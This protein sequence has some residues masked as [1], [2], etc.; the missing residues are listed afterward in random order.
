MFDCRGEIRKKESWTLRVKSVSTRAHATNERTNEQTNSRTNEQKG[1]KRALSVAPSRVTAGVCPRQGT[2]GL[3]T[4]LLHADE[5]RVPL[6]SLLRTFISL[7]Q[8]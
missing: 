5:L 8:S 7:P 6:F 3:L 1:K 4:W 2:G